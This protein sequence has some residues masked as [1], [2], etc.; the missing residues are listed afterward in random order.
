MKWVQFVLEGAGVRGL[1]VLAA[2]PVSFETWNWSGAG[3]A[4]QSC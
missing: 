3:W 4:R 2:V 1:P